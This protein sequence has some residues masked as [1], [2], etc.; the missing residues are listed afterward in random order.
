VIEQPE[1]R[2]LWAEVNG[3]P[4]YALVSAHSPPD[5]KAVVLV[6]GL[7]LS[8]TYLMP[9]AKALAPDYRVFV[10]DLPGF[11]RSGKPDHVADVSELAD[12]LAGWMAAI[13]LEKAALLGNS[14]GCQIIAECAARHPER[15]ER[16]ILQG[17]T[18]PREERTWFWQFVRW[19]Q[20]PNP[21]MGPIAHRDYRAAGLGRVLKTFQY[22]LEH[23][24]EERLERIRVPV[25]VIRGSRDPICR[26]AW[27]EEVAQ[28]LPQGRLIV[29]PGV[30]HTLVFTHALELAR[31]CR[32]FLAGED[33]PTSALRTTRPPQPTADEPERPPLAQF[34]SASALVRALGSYLNGH[35]FPLLGSYPAW[36]ASAWKTI[37]SAVN[38]L[39]TPA[40]RQVYIWSGRSEAVEPERLG[41]VRAE[42]LAE[43]SVLRYPRKPYSAVMI[44][45]SNGA[46][47]HLCVLLGIP[48][49]PQT[50]L[51]PVQ[52]S[53]ID[54]AQ[55]KA[56][57]EWGKGWGARLLAANPDLVLHHMHD[58]NQ[59]Y[60]MIQR[61]SYFRVKF[62][63]LVQTYR[64]FL[65]ETLA[66]G[67]TIFSVECNLGWPTVQIGERHIFQTGA[68]GG[69]PPEEYQQGSPRLTEFLEHQGS[70]SEQWDPPTPDGERP[71][72]EWGFEPSLRED[73]ERLVSSHGYRFV[74][75]VFDHPEDPS[76]L[77][78]DFFRAWYR[79]RRLPANRLLMANFILMEPY[80][81]IRT[82]SVPFWTVFNV[83]RSAETLD[84]YLASSDAY[85]EI[86]LMLFSHGVNSI[87]M[88]PIDRWRSILARAKRCGGFIGVD[89][90][91]Y[92]RDFATFAR[93]HTS[94]QH[95]V[96]ARH[97]IPGPV[98]LGELKT[99]LEQ[100]E[101]RYAVRWL[102][103]RNSYFS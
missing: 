30:H 84:R 94:L 50:F 73:I 44:G 34:D 41:A 18:T 97:P 60:L 87:G 9:T 80:W 77:V 96:P 92:P 75:I 56:E 88:A 45:S 3:L 70:D 14:F 67:A 63:R 58:P 72:A 28:R 99:F 29:I 48:W 93:Y 42:C 13:G 46:L 15:V 82:G 17:P 35:D 38:A 25:L 90:E 47:L 98:S 20:N 91:S 49:L 89:E 31:V 69:I 74:R 76:P 2:I 52:R 40:K 61:M 64:R 53:G 100:T 22:S 7:G 26:H 32:P 101:N 85:D 36:T 4:V 33:F 54:P 12:D 65:V 83:E 86:Y 1:F 62:R 57:M 37:G 24:M 71:E 55:P 39:P 66:P 95:A 16:A 21:D 68:L 51:I 10:P 5:A 6:H 81:T 79:R 27:A 43:W 11:G 78:A 59:D 103:D 8:G 23:P 19:R 102:S